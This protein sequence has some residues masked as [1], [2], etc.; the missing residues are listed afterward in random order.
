[1][2]K[3]TPLRLALMLAL[4]NAI[5]IACANTSSDAGTDSSTHWMNDCSSSARCGGLK[6]ECG[7]CTKP[8]DE[9]SDCRGLSASASCAAV[10][11][12]SSATTVCLPPATNSDAGTPS[13][14]G[15]CIAD[16]GG[17][18]C[19][20]SVAQCWSSCANGYRSQFVCSGGTWL[21]GKGLFPCADGAGGSSGGGTTGGDCPSTA[22]SGASCDGRIEQCWTQCSNGFRSQYTCSDGTWI[23]GFGLVPC[24]NGT[25]PAS[26]S[27]SRRR[28]A[29]AAQSGRW[30][31]TSSGSA[32]SQ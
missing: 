5:A 8:C 11:G 7:V 1:M 26:A 30:G 32:T 14:G 12:C 27:H 20:G 31:E 24:S 15:T 18:A 25:C 13:M 28:F 22:Q 16:V 10:P 6:C 29:T 4:G 21:A 23:A 17:K 3:T 9:P 19:N 2:K